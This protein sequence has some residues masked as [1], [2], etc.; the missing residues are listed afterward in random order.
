V[1]I[2][3]WHERYGTLTDTVRVRAGADSTVAF[4]YPESK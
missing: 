3:I 4:T 2:R 1:T